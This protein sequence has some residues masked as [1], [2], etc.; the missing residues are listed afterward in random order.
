MSKTLTLRRQGKF[1]I[2]TVGSNHCGME[3]EQTMKYMVTVVCKR[4]GSLDDRDYLFEQFNIDNLFQSLKHDDPTDMSCER[5]AINS[6]KE[7]RRMILDEN[8]KLKI[9][10]IEVELSAKPYAA[11]MTY[12]DVDRRFKL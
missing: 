3:K 8:P 1:K 7:I 6:G 4:K 12:L 9:M 10:S 11:S 5:L 2:N